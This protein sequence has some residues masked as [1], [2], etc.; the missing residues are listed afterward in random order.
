MAGLNTAN[1]VADY[2]VPEYLNNLNFK[3]DDRV[4]ADSLMDIVQAIRNE[5]EIDLHGLQH[6]ILQLIDS[7]RERRE[8]RAAQRNRIVEHTKRKDRPDVADRVAFHTAKWLL[9]MDNLH[10]Q[11][12]NTAVT[13]RRIS[14]DRPHGRSAAPQ[15]NT[16]LVPA[17]RANIGPDTNPTI[18]PSQA[19]EYLSIKRKSL[20]TGS[21]VGQPSLPNNVAYKRPI[22]TTAGREDPQTPPIKRQKSHHSRESS[23]ASENTEIS[24]RL[25]S[26]PA[27][28]SE[29]ELSDEDEG[30]EKVARSGSVKPKVRNSI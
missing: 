6:L 16:D 19:K 11:G 22:S 1:S 5:D 8:H 28:G 10:F 23:P 24:S 27:C 30:N 20:E 9:P 3:L 14:E 13:L 2:E 4:V 12:I 18:S 7:F 15:Y 29:G 17:R 25:S 21:Q 26:I